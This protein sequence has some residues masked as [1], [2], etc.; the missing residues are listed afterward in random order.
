MGEAFNSFR[1]VA[2]SIRE[3]W[4]LV[5]LGDQLYLR[6]LFP[7]TKNWQGIIFEATVQGINRAEGW[8]T[9]R[10]DALPQFAQTMVFNVQW[11]VQGAQSPLS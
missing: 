6:Q 8:L 3:G 10:C 7:E 2:K 9:I 1:L 4:P 5:D 11:R